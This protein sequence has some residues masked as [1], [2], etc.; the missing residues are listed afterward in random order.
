MG[1]LQAG[2]LVAS[3]QL[4]CAP[5]TRA[6][7]LCELALTDREEI[8]TFVRQWAQTLSCAC[9]TFTPEREKERERERGRDRERET[10]RER[11]RQERDRERERERARET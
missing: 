1:P 7:S 8:V 2:T 10:E 6:D 11:A 9:C 5:D 3:E 4:Q